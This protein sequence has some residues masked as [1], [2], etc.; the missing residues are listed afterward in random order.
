MA[1]SSSVT[2]DLILA[3]VWQL[4]GWCHGAS[5]LTGR[6][7]CLLYSTL[8]EVFFPWPPTGIFFS[9]ESSSLSYFIVRVSC[10]FWIILPKIL[11]FPIRHHLRV[12]NEVLVPAIFWQC[13]S[14]TPA[15]R[16]AAYFFVRSPHTNINCVFYALQE[17]N[18]NVKDQNICG[19]W[20]PPLSFVNC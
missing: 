10:L 16:H 14:N 9:L 12:T 1:S 20:S 13:K 19:L 15:L 5:S 18:L 3:E 17:Y 4:R 6:R 8:S 11:V 7:V 2:L